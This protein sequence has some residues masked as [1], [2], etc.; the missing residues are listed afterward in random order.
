MIKFSTNRFAAW[1]VK[2]VDLFCVFRDVSFARG[3]CADSMN[4]LLKF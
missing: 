3:I 4:A 1:Y 2:D